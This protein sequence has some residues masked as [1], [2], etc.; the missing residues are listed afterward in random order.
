[1]TKAKSTIYKVGIPK[2]ATATTTTTTS[3]LKQYEG[4][5]AKSHLAEELNIQSSGRGLIQVSNGANSPNHNNIVTREMLVGHLFFNSLH[6]LPVKTGRAKHIPELSENLAIAP[7]HRFYAI[8]RSTMITPLQ[9]LIKNGA[10]KPYL[11]LVSIIAYTKSD[12]IPSIH[13]H[14]YYW[15][16]PV[17]EWERSLYLSALNHSILSPLCLV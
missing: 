16:A 1:M 6:L 11:Y 14:I 2:T 4:L 15:A 10:N 13:S 12:Q 9:I 8:E 5:R 3:L 7:L 17:A